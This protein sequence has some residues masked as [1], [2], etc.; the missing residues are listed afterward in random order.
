LENLDLL[1]TKMSEDDIRADILPMTFSMLESNSIQGQASLVTCLC[2]INTR[3][4]WLQSSDQW[5]GN[6]PK[7]R[8][9]F[10]FVEPQTASETGRW[11]L[12]CPRWWQRCV[13]LSLASVQL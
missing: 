13:S 4:K 12:C 6:V 5:C 2:T 9:H 11:F 1:L 10:P 7:M 8:P 3:C